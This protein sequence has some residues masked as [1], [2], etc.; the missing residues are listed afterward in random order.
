MCCRFFPA[1]VYLASS[2]IAIAAL[3]NLAFALALCTYKVVIK[4]RIFYDFFPIKFPC[5]M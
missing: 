4:V 2:K 5:K 3:G 1:V